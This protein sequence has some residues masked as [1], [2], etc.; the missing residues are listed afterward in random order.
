MSAFSVQLKERYHVSKQRLSPR[1]TGEALA[2]RSTSA[3]DWST[4]RSYLL[5]GVLQTSLSGRGGCRGIARHDG[6]E[7]PVAPVASRASDARKEVTPLV[8]GKANV[9]VFRCL[10]GVED[11]CRRTR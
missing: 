1:Q 7:P 6:G 2:V 4:R 10:R 3:A 11:H 5:L 9:R 8:S